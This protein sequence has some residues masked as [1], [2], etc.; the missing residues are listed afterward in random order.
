MMKN[1][2]AKARQCAGFLLAATLLSG[3][4]PW[5]GYRPLAVLRYQT[6]TPPENTALVVFLRGMGGSHRSF[7][8]MGVVAAVRRQ[9]LALDM[10]APDSHF[11]YY[12]SRSLV[13]RLKEDVLDPAR[14]QGYRRIWLVGVS[15]GGLGAMM[16]LRAHPEDLAG[17]CIISPFLGYDGIVEEVAA[18]GGIRRWSPGQADPDDWE[19]IFWGWLKAYAA[20]P[21][22]RPPVYLGYGTEDRMVTGHRLLEEILPPKRVYRV[23]GG[24]R[25]EVMKR[26]LLQFLS[27]DAFTAAA[28]PETDARH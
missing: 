5:G 12:F 19:R 2:S 10:V 11:G 23:P 3:C 25:P 28:G 9:G 21:G 7:E 14:S 26:L 17:V 24:H 1:I 20:A 8:R 4:M 13:P 22:N 6:A 15:M 16:Y 27:G 18:A